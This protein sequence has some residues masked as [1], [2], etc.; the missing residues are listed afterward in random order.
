[1]SERIMDISDDL[2]Q[3]ANPGDWGERA[4]PHRR[5]RDLYDKGLALAN[6]GTPAALAAAV[7]AYDEAIGLWQGLDLGVAEYRNTLAWAHNQKGLALQHQGTPA[8][9]AAAVAAHDEAIGLW[10]G[11]DLGVAEHRDGLAGAQV[12]KGNALTNQASPAALEAALAAYG[13]AIGLLKGFDLATD[14]SR[15]FLANACGSKGNALQRQGTPAALA[16]AVAALD[17]A[18]HLHQGLDLGVAQ[19]RN[20]LAKVHGSKGN[21]LLQQGTPAALAAAVAAYDEAIGLATA[22]PGEELRLG[23]AD[24]EATSY[25]NKAIVLLAQ[26]DP[27]NAADAADEGLGRLRDLERA[28][29]HVLRVQR[30]KLFDL[31]LTGYLSARQPQFIPE[32]IR[33]HLD[34]AEPGSAPASSAMHW[35]ASEALR[36]GMAVLFETGRSAEWV[37]GLVLAMQR[38]TEWRQLYFGGTAESA[39]LQAADLEGRGDPAQA[40]A[41]LRDYAEARPRDPEGHLALAEFQVRHQ[42]APA[43]LDCYQRAAAVLVQ[44]APADADRDD[45]VRRVAQVAGQMLDLKRIE[46]GQGAPAAMDTR[47]LFARREALRDWLQGDFVDLLFRDAAGVP[48]PGLA[49]EGW[50][51]LLDPA[52]DAL[53]G[54]VAAELENALEARTWEQAKSLSLAMTR[55]LTQGRT[56][57]WA[58]F[59][60]TITQ[61]WAELPP[62]LLERLAQGDEAGRRAIQ[63]EID[64][65]LGPRVAQWSRAV[66]AGELGAAEAR[67]EALL[68]PVWTRVL[69]SDERRFLA[70][71]LRFLEQDG[72]ARHAGIEFGL[73]LE[74][75]LAGRVFRPLREAWR[76]PGA[77]RAQTP[78]GD[79][80]IADQV[81]DFL[82]GDG[83]DLSLGPMVATLLRALDHGAA[84]ADPTDRLLLG[85][86]GAFPNQAHLFPG[87]PGLHERRT[88]ALNAVV[89]LRNQCAHGAQA[90]TAEAVRG[91]WEDLVADPADAFYQ[92]FGRALL[93]AG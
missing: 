43:A 68:G 11:L 83:R 50:R 18:I 79:D 19:Y 10:Q 82:E 52:L 5:A 14:Q 53:W 25:G 47:T 3:D 31:T 38:L 61:A 4:D 93:P 15:E 16:A 35:A 74:C 21:A 12:N 30:E 58:E 42:A 75:S 60:D 57:G 2:G 29:V 80:W 26:N 7:A 27:M 40:Q 49:T 36:K 46:P 41:L 9:L 64:K 63:D 72:Q 24:T 69:G 66:S 51:A 85:R 23:R 67:L 56:T 34:P 45:I 71:G 90:P 13:E 84:A 70:C 37:A 77:A 78:L 20:D 6:Q 89:R 91:M 28:G 54:P 32:I 55:S 33:E 44:Q 62:R 48:L 22:R 59:E 65:A 17:E 87:T 81:A 39:R 1:M 8:A 88:K 73:A 92:Y 86:I 76:A